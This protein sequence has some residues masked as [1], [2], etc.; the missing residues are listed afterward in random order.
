MY[1][2]QQCTLFHNFICLLNRCIESNEYCYG[3]IHVHIIIAVLL[4]SL[5]EPT[6]YFSLCTLMTSLARLT[7]KG[8]PSLIF[9]L[10]YDFILLF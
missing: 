5:D 8:T 1:Q 6:H 4:I 7:L 3:L 9:I 10:F 2:L